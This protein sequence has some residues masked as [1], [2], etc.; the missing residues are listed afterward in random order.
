MLILD[1]KLTVQHR[2]LEIVSSFKLSKFD[3]Q[4]IEREPYN[5]IFTVTVS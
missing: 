2:E 1:H 3:M 4:V 5:V